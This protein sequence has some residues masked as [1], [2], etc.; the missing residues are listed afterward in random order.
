MTYKILAPSIFALLAAG[1][2]NEGGSTPAPTPGGGARLSTAGAP[3]V[4]GDIVPGKLVALSLPAPT[5]TATIAGSDALAP[6]KPF[7]LETPALPVTARDV[8]RIMKGDP[9]TFTLAVDAPAG[10]RVIV[11]PLDPN[12]TLPTVHLIDVAT[13]AQLDLARDETNGVN[14]EHVLNPAVDSGGT[15]QSA[16]GMPAPIANSRAFV[17]EPGFEPLLIHTR[18][19]SFDRPY[20]SGMVRVQVPAA[21][22]AS[23]IFVELQQ[24][25]THFTITTVADEPNHTLGDT[26]TIT[27]TLMNDSA[28]ITSGSVDLTVEL[29]NHAKLAPVQLTSQGNGTWTTQLPLNSVDPTTIGV[30]GLKVHATGSVAG[31]QFE[32][33]V[34]TALGYFPAHAQVTALGTPVIARGSDG[35]VDSVSVDVDVQTLVDDRFS[36]RGTLTYTGEDGAEHP[37]ASA[38]TGQLIRKGTGTMTLRFDNTSMALAQVNG[39][40]HLRDLALVSQALGFT[41]FRLGRALDIQTPPIAASEIRYPKTIPITAQDLIDNGDLQ[42]RNQ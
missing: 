26:A 22:A 36:V 8:H 30:W 21:V 20:T 28:P 38:Q 31:V 34:E 24:P 17:R 41:E 27:A 16:K 37:L 12:M 29:P 32:R 7:A 9:S 11:R 5:E 1:C 2:S 25:N 19:L 35:L 33:D 40:F 39:P 42:A 6:K 4:H 3:R 14:T 18:V 10:A 23:G 15:L 13:G